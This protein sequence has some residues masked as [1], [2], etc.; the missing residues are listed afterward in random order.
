MPIRPLESGASTADSPIV[1]FGGA[2]DHP[3]AGRQRAERRVKHVILAGRRPHSGNIRKQKIH[4]NHGKSKVCSFSVRHKPSAHYFPDHDRRPRGLGAGSGRAPA[5]VLGMLETAPHAAKLRADGGYQGP[6][7]ASALK[8]LGIGPVLEI[9]NKPKDVMGSAVLRR[10]SVVEQTFIW[11]SRCRHL[12][13]DYEP[14][15]D[16]S[17]ARAQLAAC[18]FMMRRIGRDENSGNKK[19]M[20]ILNFRPY[21]RRW[22][23]KSP[24][25]HCSF[26]AEHG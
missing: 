11:M 10:R 14:S 17:S 12:A 21:S 8:D 25:R 2:F 15:L 22:R 4:F 19:I 23:T 13:K 1:G 3:V 16:R 24:T 6:K 9:V 26:I 20:R 18:R 5:A 7:L